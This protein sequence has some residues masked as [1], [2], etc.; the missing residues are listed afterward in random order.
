MAD[1]WS[2]TTIKIS[3]EVKH[4]TKRMSEIEKDARTLS[5]KVKAGARITM[6]KLSGPYSGL[7]K[8]YRKEKLTHDQIRSRK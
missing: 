7:K 6:Y 5:Y 4:K 1:S 8:E 3:K 2:L